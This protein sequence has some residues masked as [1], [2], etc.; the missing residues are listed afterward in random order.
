ME[1]DGRVGVGVVSVSHRAGCN[2]RYGMVRCWYAF[3]GREQ[4][5]VGTSGRASL[6]M[7]TEG[8]ERYTKLWI[9]P[10]AVFPAV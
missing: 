1:M 4:R 7:R 10:A 6:G 5:R 9:S 8:W 3:E 2:G